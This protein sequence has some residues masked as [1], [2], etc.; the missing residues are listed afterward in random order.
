MLMLTPEVAMFSPAQVTTL[1]EALRSG[2]PLAVFSV[3][4]A[5]ATAAIGCKMITI[6]RYRPDHS[7]LERVYS[8]RPDDYPVGGSKIKG[9]TPWKQQLLDEGRVVLSNDMDALRVNFEDSG[10]LQAL[11]IDAILNIPI[12]DQG[13]CR[14]TLN[15]GHCSGW[16][17]QHHIDVGTVLAALLVSAVVG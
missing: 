5:I 17:T 2:Q 11:G 12:V 7:T 8:N 14:G 15:F 16:F 6:M 4:D 9:Q 13:Q 3:I 10:A 1:S